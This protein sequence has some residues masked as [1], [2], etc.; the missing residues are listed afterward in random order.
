MKTKHE[1]KITQAD[2]LME[3]WAG[4]KED[5]SKILGVKPKTGFRARMILAQSEPFKSNPE[6]ALGCARL[7]LTYNIMTPK[8][9]PKLE[10]SFAV[11]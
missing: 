9:L 4:R 5:K 3:D 7:C 10:L 1:K 11:L 8:D 6:Y 2:K